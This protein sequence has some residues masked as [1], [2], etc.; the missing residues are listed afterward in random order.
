MVAVDERRVGCGG[1]S[2]RWDQVS[3]GLVWC[4][5]FVLMSWDDGTEW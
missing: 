2:N 5:C 4:G 1:A 3:T